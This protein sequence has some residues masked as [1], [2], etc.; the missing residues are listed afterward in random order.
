MI[1]LSP[2]P[3]YTWLWPYLEIG[4]FQTQWS[5]DEVL[6]NHLKA[7]GYNHPRS[8]SHVSG[9][10]QAE[11][12]GANTEGSEDWFLLETPGE[13]LFPSFPDFWRLNYIPGLKGSTVPLQSQLR[14]LFDLS[15]TAAPRFRQHTAPEESASVLLISSACSSD[16]TCVRSYGSCCLSLTGLLFT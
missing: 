4:A 7:G 5:S 3:Q 8:L 1:C 14:A 13:N 12:Q 11:F 16:S 2:N 15:D 9:R 10:H 6:L